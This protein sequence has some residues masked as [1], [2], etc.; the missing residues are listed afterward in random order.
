MT[1][2]PLPFGIPIHNWRDYRS[3]KPLLC[4][5]MCDICYSEVM[6]VLKL[7][8]H[9]V[10][11]VS[12]K[13]REFM[14]YCW[15]F[16]GKLGSSFIIHLRIKI[17]KAREQSEHE[18]IFAVPEWFMMNLFQITSQILEEINL[19]LNLEVLSKKS[20]S[21]SSFNIKL[22]LVLYQDYHLLVNHKGR[23]NN[24]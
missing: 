10:W 24:V 22:W 4:S 12:G 23:Q 21:I 9:M 6:Y 1:L 20:L 18:W 14:A 2:Q 16:L 17:R 11:W 15:S 7:P 3:Q 8:V 19:L 13:K 5:F